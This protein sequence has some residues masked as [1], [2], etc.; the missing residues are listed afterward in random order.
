[1]AREDGTTE[2]ILAEEPLEVRLDGHPVAVLMRTPGADFEL[3]VGFLH[4][5]GL[6]DAAAEVA[7]VSYCREAG[8]TRGPTN[9]V[10][11]A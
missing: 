6:I 7:G 4:A 11:V 9:R 8:E 3:A 10:S 1:M 5:E 2:E